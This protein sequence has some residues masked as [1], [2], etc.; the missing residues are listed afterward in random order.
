MNYW[1]ATLSPGS[2]RYSILFVLAAHQGFTDAAGDRLGRNWRLLLELTYHFDA[3]LVMTQKS[4]WGGNFLLYHSRREA[5]CFKSPSSVCL[6]TFE[7]FTCR[8]CGIAGCIPSG[9]NSC[10]LLLRLC[11]S[12]RSSAATLWH[13]SAETGHLSHLCTQDCP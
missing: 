1:A 9:W 11:R 7:P 8:F 6:V 10:T 13:R 4:A 5:T 2:L 3:L 12:C